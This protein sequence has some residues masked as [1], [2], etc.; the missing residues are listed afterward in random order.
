MTTS[1]PRRRTRG[2]TRIGE[3]NPFLDSR[4]RGKDAKE[5]RKNKEK[6]RTIF[7]FV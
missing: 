7:Y 5:K 1:F 3:A 2:F 4:L 6:R